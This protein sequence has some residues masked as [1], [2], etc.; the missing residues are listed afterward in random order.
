LQQATAS[1]LRQVI[2]KT[3][4]DQVLTTG[5]AE[6]RDNVNQQ[7]NKILAIYSAGIAITDVALQPARAPEQVKDAFDDAIKA[8]EDEQRY[9]NQAEAYAMGVVPIA[10]GKAQRIVQEAQAYRQQ[11]VLQANADVARFLAILPT[12]QAAP[13]VTRDRLYISTL[14]SILEHSQKVFVDTNNANNLLYLPLNKLMGNKKIEAENNVDSITQS[15]A[16]SGDVTTT[17]NDDTSRPGRF[18]TNP[19]GQTR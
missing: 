13:S 12:Y 16:R 5:R 8:Q 7:L 1:A 17:Q 11:V 14:E 19:D 2:G 3:T 4:L 15:L 6:V 9:K 18:S 10:Q